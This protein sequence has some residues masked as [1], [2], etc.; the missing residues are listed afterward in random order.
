MSPGTSPLKNGSRLATVKDSF[1]RSHIAMD[2][3]IASFNPP[4]QNCRGYRWIGILLISTA[5]S[6]S[7]WM[8]GLTRDLSRIE[9]ASA[10]YAQDFMT[11]M[12]NYA[13]AVLQ[14]EPLRI[15]ALE[16]VQ[17]EMGLQTPKDICR[18]TKLSPTVKKICTNFYNESAK[19]I[20][21]NGLSNLEFN[22]ITEKVH[23]DPLYQKRL[24][25]EIRKRQ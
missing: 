5:V 4:T 11:R 14:M 25:A 19:I 15:D 21:R 9:G 23:S 12:G 1:F 18:Q 24:N 16:K 7:G 10:A 20:Q 8:P 3:L 6:L 17:E 13:D 2:N 22:Q